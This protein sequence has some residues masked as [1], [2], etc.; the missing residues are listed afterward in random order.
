MPIFGGSTFERLLSKATDEQ[1][2]EPDWMG[3]LAMCDL[4]R[5]QEIS[6]S[7]ALSAIRKLLFHRNS[8]VVMN[9]LLVLECLVKNCG[10]PMH[11]Q[12]TQY[13]FLEELKELVRTGYATVRTKVLSLVASWNE[14]FKGEYRYNSVKEA[15]DALKVEGFQFPELNNSEDI[16]DAARVR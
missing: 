6:T 13:E 1:V 5:Q 10:Q 14:V 15:F 2:T 16:F 12:V 4:V 9:S 7:S 11:E 8:Q 3:M